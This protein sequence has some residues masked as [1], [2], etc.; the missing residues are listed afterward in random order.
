MMKAYDERHPSLQ[1]EQ[2]F[3]ALDENHA[4]RKYDHPRKRFCTAIL[5]EH[6]LNRPHGAWVYNGWLYIADS[7]Q[8]RV[9]RLNL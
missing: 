8:N 6:Q 3:I 7:F 4:I 1:V 5:D 2:V 9:L